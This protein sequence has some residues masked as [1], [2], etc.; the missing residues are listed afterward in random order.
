MSRDTAKALLAMLVVIAA[1][2]FIYDYL[3]PHG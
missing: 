1:A 2:M 3:I